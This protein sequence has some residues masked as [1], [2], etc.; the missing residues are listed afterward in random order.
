M[1][2][3]TGNKVSDARLVAFADPNGSTFRDVTGWTGYDLSSVREDLTI[4]RM[5]LFVHHHSGFDNPT[6]SSTSAVHYGSADHWAGS[7][8]SENEL[9]REAAI[10]RPTDQY[11]LY[12]WNELPLDLTAFDAR[13][14]LRDGWISLGIGMDQNDYGYVMFYSSGHPTLSPYLQVEGYVC[15]VEK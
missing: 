3:V 10:S 11:A 15:E 1:C 14:D 5:S 8:V 7:V 13:A 2:Q 9:R 4:T 12:D 6:A